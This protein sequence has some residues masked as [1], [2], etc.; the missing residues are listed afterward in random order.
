MSLPLLQVVLLFFL[1]TALPAPAQPRMPDRGLLEPEQQAAPEDREIPVA[2]G[3]PTTLL[4]DAVLDQ[5]AVQRVSRELGLQR[6]AIG[7]DTLTFQLPPGLPEG[8]RLRLRARFADGQC[9]ESVSLVLVV[10]PSRAQSHAA[11]PRRSLA[12]LSCEEALG[13]AR[14]LAAARDGELLT[15]HEELKTKAG[16]L[17]ELVAT[18][19]LTEAGVRVIPVPVEAVSRLR[20]VKVTAARVYVARGRMA[21]EL[22]MTL[23]HVRRTPLWTPGAVKLTLNG[24]PAVARSVRLLEGTVRQGKSTA[25]L[26]V[27]WEAP[28]AHPDKPPPPSAL[29]VLGQGGKPPLRVS[30][31]GSESCRREGASWQK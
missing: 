5:L 18:D 4:F 9:P 16:T 15:L 23:T 19:V 14:A 30:C 17:A 27:E 7:E 26:I 6:V 31:L 3:L 8:T 22:V 29:E 20:G 25:R 1:L 11:V 13:A 24:T 21:A 12:A 2:A 10:D 28:A